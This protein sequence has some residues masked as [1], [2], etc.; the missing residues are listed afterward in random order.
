M[1][2]PTFEWKN[3][4]LKQLH[5]ENIL[6]RPA[7]TPLHQLPFHKNSPTSKLLITEQLSR[8]IINLPSSASLIR[9]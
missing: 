5:S 3:Q 6:A 1:N 2:E 8:R 4:L 9:E 7:W